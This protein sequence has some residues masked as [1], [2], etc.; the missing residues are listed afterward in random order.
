[1]GV[2]MLEVQHVSFEIFNLLDI[3]GWNG[4]QH[5]VSG[6]QLQRLRGTPVFQCAVHLHFVMHQFAPHLLVQLVLGCELYLF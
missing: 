6:R 3:L 5:S 2:N 4:E 1:M